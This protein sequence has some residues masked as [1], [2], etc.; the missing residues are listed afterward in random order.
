MS[1]NLRAA[2]AAACFSLSPRIELLDRLRRRTA[3][4]RGSSYI[5]PSATYQSSIIALFSPLAINQRPSGT[6]D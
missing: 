4:L 2:S 1:E 5:H 6:P 3:N